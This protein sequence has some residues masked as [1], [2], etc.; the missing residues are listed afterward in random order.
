M[1]MTA[2]G[3]AIAKDLLLIKMHYISIAILAHNLVRGDT[4]PTF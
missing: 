3:I 1:F 2:P 4:V